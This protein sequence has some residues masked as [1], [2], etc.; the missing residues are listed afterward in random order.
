LPQIHVTID[1]TMISKIDSIFLIENLQPKDVKQLNSIRVD[2]VENKYTFYSL[3][4]N[5]RFKLK[6]YD[7]TE[8]LSDFIS[9]TKSK[10]KVKIDK[11][12][13]EVVFKED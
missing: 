6:L 1:K 7:N 12:G 8:I 3:Q 13:D 2:G 9:I 11:L 10:T 4:K 5:V